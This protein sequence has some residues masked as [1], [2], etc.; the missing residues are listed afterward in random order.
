VRVTRPG[1]E[2]YSALAAKPLHVLVF[3]IPLMLAYEVGAVLYLSRPG[4]METIGAH[5]IVARLFEVFGGFTLH[6]PTIL[7][8]VVLLVWHLLLR[9]PWRV[10]PAVLLGMTFESCLWTLPLLVLGLILDAG[11]NAGSG[12][13][14]AL[15]QP[16]INVYAQSWQA[17]LT[18][19]IGAGLYEELLFRLMLVT[20]LHLVLVDF[21]KI[22]NRWGS[23][24]AALL[25]GVAFALYHNVSLRE[26]SGVMVFA[27]YT[28][29][30]TYFATLF[31]LRGFGIVVAAHAI[32]DTVVLVA[33][34]GEAS[35]G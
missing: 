15:A 17:R 1:E 21:L 30:G 28:L 25:S 29:A 11:L 33:L 5:R 4:L 22:E 6:A 12:P 13:P 8:A 26:S 19:S 35:G 32:Y 14:A 27:F 2:G 18:L 24:L 23:A 10:R 34:R 7:L 16:A 31:M 20:I 3:L 9:D